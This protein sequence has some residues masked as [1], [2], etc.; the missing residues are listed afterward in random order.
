M[1]ERRS[2]SLV[3]RRDHVLESY[4]GLRKDVALALGVSPYY[5]ESRRQRLRW[6][7]FFA[8][9]T[10]LIAGVGAAAASLLFPYPFVW[11]CVSSVGV[12]CAAAP[13]FLALSRGRLSRLDETQ[14][15]TRRS[16]DALPAVLFPQK[17]ANNDGPAGLL[18]PERAIVP[19]L[20]RAPQLRA[21]TEWCEAPQSVSMATII[22]APGVGKTRLALE[23]SRQMQRRGWYCSWLS[24]RH[25]E[26]DAVFA[27]ARRQPLLL[28]I[29]DAELADVSSHLLQ[30]M[31]E[32]TDSWRIRIV[33]AGRDSGEWWRCLGIYGGQ[34]RNLRDR[35]LTLEL[36]RPIDTELQSTLFADAISAFSEILGQPEPR[37][38]RL[39]KAEYD[40]ILTIQ[41]AALLSILDNRDWGSKRHINVAELSPAMALDRLLAYESHS[42][43][44]N[45][46]R[47]GV[48]GI[49]AATLRHTIAVSAL[50]GIPEEIDAERVLQHVS[51]LSD[52]DME[53]RRSLVAW[54][55]SM[56]LKG[57]LPRK[58]IP[59]SL[60]EALIVSELE[61]DPEL[62]VTAVAGINRH[63]AG[64]AL[65]TLARAGWHPK[66]AQ[67]L[68]YALFANIPTM[69]E[70]IFDVGYQWPAGMGKVVAGVLERERNMSTSGLLKI[71]AK[72]PHRSVTLARVSLIVCQRLT[73]TFADEVPERANWLGNLSRSLSNMGQFS[74]AR[75]AADEAT[76]LYR[77]FEKKNPDAY[78]PE[79][80]A[81]LNNLGSRWAQV[82]R[83]QEALDCVQEAVALSRQLAD[84]NPDAYLPELAASLNNLGSRWAQVGRVQEALDC[85]Q[86]AVAL[87]RQLA[88][89]NPDAYLPELAASLNNLGS[90]W[91]QVGR[92]QEALDCVQEA[93]ALSRQLADANPDAYLP[94]L[95][96]S[97]NNLGSR[98][99]QVGRVQEALDC[100]QEAVALSRQ[101]ADANPDAYLPEL[102]ASLNNLGSRWAQVG[103]VQEALDCV[104]E[105]VALSRQLAD[106]NPD[107]YLPELAASLNNLGTC[108][109]DLGRA[110]EAFRVVAEATDIYRKAA[111]ANPDAYLP[112]LAA[113]LNNLGT[114]LNDLGRAEE[115][116][117]VVAE[118]TDIYRKA[119]DANPDAYLP[120]LAA[121][122]NNLGICLND[123]GRAEEAQAAAEEGLELYHTL[124]TE[125]PDVMLPKLASSFSDLSNKLIA[126]GHSHAAISVTEECVPIWRKLVERDRQAY[127]PALASALHKLAELYFRVERGNSSVDAAQKAAGIYRELDRR[128]P[129]FFTALLGAS[130]RTLSDSLVSEGRITEARIAAAEAVRY[131]RRLSAIQPSY[132]VNLATALESLSAIL[133]RLAHE[134]EARVA[135]KQAAEIRQRMSVTA[136]QNCSAKP[137]APT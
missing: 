3:Q 23:L 126:S 4:A 79:L 77:M 95:A 45:A 52:L 32:V 124:A 93:V 14:A 46:T 6:T 81:S 49:D 30:Q 29:D 35:P 127:L 16:R 86:E 110:E 27:A 134:E 84:A 66:A 67:A 132:M 100:V 102:A 8:V 82:G 78:L 135:S 28:V 47:W 64:M 65:L 20:G 131:Y 41:A 103:R 129:H 74:Q 9:G 36:S 72:I 15:L 59:D 43:L 87:S 116:F 54:L 136:V 56:Y 60:T 107:A 85:V 38:A 101:L 88:D 21:L 25:S 99:A 89:A 120:E 34:G 2:S 112:E 58:L 121:S 122:L 33:L 83:V 26:W 71:G 55:N 76:R 24:S 40:S 48:K 106:A 50:L 104:Q 91:A 57:S 98:W 12:A 62:A 70:A 117:R 73:D 75:T 44:E 31:L 115:A 128:R 92:V 17:E 105:A 111:D 42:W 61:S 109:N 137:A 96:A 18:R 125:R 90:R 80:A 19:L 10:G 63:Q 130:L 133:D 37:E 94:E 11:V 97:L 22:G 7:A 68:K 39:P 119:A 69:V 114:C 5:E 123:L 108:L 1:T 51:D 53:T 113:S 13:G 118:A